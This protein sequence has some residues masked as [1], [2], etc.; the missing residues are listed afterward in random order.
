MNSNDDFGK[1]NCIGENTHG[2]K[3]ASV[4]IQSIYLIAFSFFNFEKFTVFIEESVP[5][6]S[7]TR[8]YQRHS[9]TSLHRINST[10]KLFRSTT[11]SAKDVYMKREISISSSSYRLRTHHRLKDFLLLLLV[12][13]F[14]QSKQ[15]NR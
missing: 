7:T 11:I 2:R 3:E 1:Y 6:I 12:L 15:I 5:I 10:R 8:K 4:Y 13:L 9:K 14:C